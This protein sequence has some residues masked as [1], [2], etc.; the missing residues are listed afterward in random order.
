MVIV[1]LLG[2]IFGGNQL[3]N[4][5]SLKPITFTVFIGAPGQQP[6]P[7]N[8]I[9]KMIQ[10]EL[11]VTLKFEYLVGDIDQKLGVMIAGGDYPDIVTGHTRLINAGALIP[12]EDLIKKN[13][14][15]LWK[16]YQPYLNMVKEPSDGHFYIMP[17]YGRYYGEYR[18]TDFW[19]PAFYIQKAVLKEFGYPK[20]K[21]LD[22]YFDL[23]EKYKAKYPEIDGMP[24]IGFE[25]LGYSWRNWGL[26]NPPQHLIGHPNDGGV[27]VDYKGKTYKAE[28][29]A[30]KDYAKRYY[31]K[32]NDMNAKGLIDRE[33]FTL[34]Y[35]QYMA[36]MSSGR[37]LGTFDQK[38]NFNNANTSLIMQN[39]IERTY[40]P[41]AP[42]FDP[43]TTKDWYMDRTVLNL[44]NGFAITKNC[45]DPVRFLKF[46]DALMSEKWQ[47]IIQWGI[48]GEDYMVDNKGVFYCTPEQRTHGN[49]LTWRLANRAQTIIDYAPKMEGTFKDGNSTSAGIQPGE[50]YDALRPF[51]KEFLAGYKLKTWADFYSTPPENPIPYPAWNINLIEG[52]PAKV[53]DTKLN[54]LSMKWLP[55][56]ILADPKDFD[57][58]WDQYV[59]EI[60]KLDIKAYEDRIN[61]QIQWRLKNW[62]PTKK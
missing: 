31:K 18:V 5:K 45:K 52:T 38:W 47:K 29:F 41:T 22:E 30:D 23:I 2:F 27:V 55:Q 35:D 56:V 32:L 6:T 33:T 54:D 44:N 60:H 16:H 53:T 3:I 58:L 26:K 61:E 28:I 34:T 17:N 43:K 51:D 57:K 11:G 39:K 19:G 25:I 42:V 14:P 49:D 10:K 4:A 62:S 59:A 20:V 7:D 46:L 37:V 24:T 36:K 8:K 1:L 15:N 40:A 12:L 48:K 21:S 50:F 13:C 9:Y